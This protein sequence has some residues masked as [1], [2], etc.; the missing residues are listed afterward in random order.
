MASNQ[1]AVLVVAEGAL[2]PFVHGQQAKKEQAFTEFVQF[3]RQQVPSGVSDV[4][5]RYLIRDTPPNAYDL[6]LCK[7]TG[8]LMVDTALAG[9]TGCSVHLW[10]G[11]FVLVPFATATCKLKQVPTWSYLLQTLLDR[12]R[13]SLGG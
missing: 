7:W 2:L 8:K 9:F 11:D 6:I 13:I 12:E 4:R 3:L 5:A 1:H 10:Q